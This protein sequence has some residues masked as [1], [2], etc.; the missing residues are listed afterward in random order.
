EEKDHISSL[1]SVKKQ[2][3]EDL[4]ILLKQM[5]CLHLEENANKAE[6]PSMIPSEATQVAVV[7]SLGNH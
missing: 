2:M 3:R 5:V 1:V 4:I 7:S 6:N